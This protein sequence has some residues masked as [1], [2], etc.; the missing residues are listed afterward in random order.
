MRR[1]SHAWDVPRG[2]GTAS[3]TVRGYTRY[4]EATMSRERIY[5]AEAIGVLAVL[6]LLLSGCRL[7][8]AAPSPALTVLRS[9]TCHCR[10][11]YPGSWHFAPSNGDYSRPTLGLA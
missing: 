10:F 9:P 11:T 2:C 7:P 1:L 6:P 3:S 8:W 4:N 5:R